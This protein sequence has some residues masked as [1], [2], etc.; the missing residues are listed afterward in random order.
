VFVV[1]RVGAVGGKGTQDRTKMF[2]PYKDKK[3]PIIK[4]HENPPNGSLVVPCGRTDGQT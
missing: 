2:E 3:S 4:F 1:V